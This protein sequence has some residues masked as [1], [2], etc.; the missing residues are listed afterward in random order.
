MCSMT[1]SR[2]RVW[3]W[4]PSG[5]VLHAE[6]FGTIWPSVP[7][8][9]HSLVNS[10]RA[11]S[12]KVGTPRA[13]QHRWPLCDKVDTIFDI[14]NHPL[15]P[16]NGRNDTQHNSKDNP[17]PM[18]FQ[19]HPEDSGSRDQCSLLTLETSEMWLSCIL[20]LTCPLSTWGEGAC[21]QDEGFF[22]NQ[23]PSKYWNSGYPSVCLMWPCPHATSFALI[24]TPSTC[25]NS[26]MEL[27]G[28]LTFPGANR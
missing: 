1:P 5:R 25:P 4:M 13:P 11:C 14:A 8:A 24:L 16:A 6:H 26:F 7:P 15:H 12:M 20:L 17:I 28:H 2:L 19:G 18:M 22:S 3:G 27:P 9:V 21:F 23:V 10:E